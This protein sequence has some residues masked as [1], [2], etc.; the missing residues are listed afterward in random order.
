[1]AR[2]AARTAE[3]DL[4]VHEHDG[5]VGDGE[6]E[7]D[8]LLDEHDGRALLVGDAADGGEHRFDDRRR[9]S[10]AEL[11]DEQDRRLL[12]ERA[13]GGEHLLLAAGQVAGASFQRGSSAGNRSSIER[14]RGP[15]LRRAASR[16]SAT[17]RP[18][19][20]RPVVGHEHEPGLRCRT[21]VAAAELGAVHR[22]LAAEAREQAGQ[23][24][25][26][27]RLAGAVRPDEREHLARRDLEVD[28]ADERGSRDG[29]RRPSGTRARRW[30]RRSVARSRRAHGTTT[31]R[32]A[33]LRRRFA[34]SVRRG[35][36]SGL[37]RVEADGLAA[38][39]GGADALVVAH[40]LRRARRDQLAEVE[41]LHVV[42]EVEDQLQVVV[43]EEDR[44]ALVAELAEPGAEPAAVGRCR[45]PPRAR[46]GGAPT[47]DRRARARSTRAGGCP[48]RARSP[49]ARPP[50]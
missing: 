21:R 15:P 4:A 41:H 29:R 11:V 36:R 8:V 23:G 13:G 26:E 42:A 45:A 39:V 19:E 9:E 48:A 44:D 1:M 47:G 43:D 34:T 32:L 28:V 27:R 24:E 5:V 7:A 14:A 31:G 2:S 50:A 12:H 30:R 25:Q 3:R 18:G 49:V 16:F 38:D 22:H 10:E 37:G 17:V 35:P 33:L 6:R 20:Q 46:R 40:R